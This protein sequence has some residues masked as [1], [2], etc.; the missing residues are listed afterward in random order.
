MRRRLTPEQ[1]LT[2]TVK[3]EAAARQAQREQFELDNKKFWAE[4]EELGVKPTEPTKMNAP[5][6]SGAEFGDAPLAAIKPTTI[7]RYRDKWEPDKP[8]AV[9]R[10][11][12]FMSAV[13]SWAVEQGYMSSNPAKGVRK[14]SSED[15]DRYV[16]Q[17]EMRAVQE[18]C[19][20]SPY[21]AIFMEIAYLC[22]GRVDE[23]PVH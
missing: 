15:R 16:S 20:G 5:T 12:Q 8:V 22:R 19:K 7:A 3:D 6:K 11:M 21:L 18:N 13:F 23:L 1:E 9:A 17:A 2:D 14:P 10:E 4:M